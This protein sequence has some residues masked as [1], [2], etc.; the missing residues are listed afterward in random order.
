MFVAGEG[1][2][3]AEGANDGRDLGW[4]L[5]VAEVFQRLRGNLA[6]DRDVGLSLW[7]P[8]APWRSSSGPAVWVAPSKLWVLGL[9]HLGRA[10]LWTLGLL[11]FERPTDVELTLQDF[12][13]LAPGER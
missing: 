12:D 2:R 6:G 10:F 7:D 1:E 13:R 4:C 11:P 8:R 3:L 5:A 9:G